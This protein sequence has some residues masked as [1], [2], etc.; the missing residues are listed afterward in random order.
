MNT[1][2]RYTA[3]PSPSLTERLERTLAEIASEI[4]ALHLPKLAGVV[5]GGGYGR[6]EGGV[7]HTPEGD[8]LYNDLDFFVFARGASRSEAARI[9]RELRRLAELREKDSEAALDFGPAKNLS[10]LRRVAATLMFQE[11]R[12]G[13]RPVWGD[14]DPARLIPELAPEE[15]PFSEAARL[16]LNRG[17]GLIF[18]G[19][20][21]SAG[22][23]DPDFILR[24]IH[25]AALGAGDALLLA[26][27]LYRWRGADRLTAFSEYAAREGMPEEY[28]TLYAEA[29]RYKVEPDPTLPADP[30]AMWRQR[31][32]FYLDAVRR[33]AG[34][35]RN[36]TAAE[37]AAGLSH[38]AAGE[39][40]FR[41]LLRWLRRTWQVR[42]TAGAF[43]APVVTALGRLYRELS[44]ST[45]MPAASPELRRLWGA[46]N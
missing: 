8:R 41:N 20:Y 4:G 38:R 21:L 36:A 18:A 32:D 29:F 5:L 17:M 1:T 44:H 27:G 10:A 33:A 12:R 7:R 3:L 26:A 30:A 16:L 22:K 13:W 37:T 39:R 28:A 23:N 45:G 34:A 14:V 15:L 25:K 31:R 42:F 2:F 35:P 46:F 40:S 43:D 11:L 24:N 19:E 6:G 9:D